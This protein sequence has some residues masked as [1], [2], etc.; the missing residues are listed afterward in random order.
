M[1][2]QIR[3]LKPEERMSME[4]AFPVV[5]AL[6]RPIGNQVLVQFRS[7]KQRVGLIYTTDS[8][9]EFEREK[10]RVAKV[11]EFG[12]LCWK[13]RDTQQPWPEGPW[14]ALGQFI[15]T[16]AY[17][18]TDRWRVMIEDAEATEQARAD[19]RRKC[20][21]V[22]ARIEEL[23]RAKNNSATPLTPREQRDLEAT[24]EARKLER[25]PNVIYTDVE[26]GM[27]NDYDMKGIITGNPLD[28]VDYI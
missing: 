20:G 11:L 28:I 8:D 14:V 27:F 19:W 13:D 5:D 17:A 4:E 15:R 18:N 21:E 26:F 1:P 23:T 24:V 9:Q 3:V 22:D 7:P 16:P 12:T 2:A 25:E 6:I 10:I